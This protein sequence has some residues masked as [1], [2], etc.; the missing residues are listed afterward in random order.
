MLPALCAIPFAAGLLAFAVRRDGPRRVLLV[1]A[2]A[3]HAALA[4]AVWLEPPTEA[5]AGAWF[6]LDAA[7]CLFL[8]LTS[9]LFLAASVYAVGYLAR[10]GSGRREDFEEGF[11]FANA[12]EAVFAGCLLLFLGT[13]TLV[14]ASQHLGMLWVAVEATTLASAP[15][16]YFHRHR[17]S[18]EATWKY[19]LVCSVGIAVALLGTFLLA[20]AC[21]GQGDGSPLVLG[22]LVGA[23]PALA[24]PWL[25]AAFAL[26]LVGYGTK[27][28]LA[29]FHAWLPDAHSEAPSVV[30]ALLS[31]ALLNCAFLGILRAGQVLGA[32]GHAAF[33]RELLVVFGILSMALAA[34]FIVRQ[35]DYKRMLA[36]SS[37][38]HMGILALGVGL[39]GSAV[40]GALLHAVNHSLTKGALFLV[41]GNVLAAY[42]TKSTSEVRGILRTLPLS[43]VLW[44]LG[45]LAVAGSPPFGPFL[46]ELVIFK[47]AV[48]GGHLLIAAAY[49]ALLALVFAGMSATVLGMSLGETPEAPGAPARPLRGE[50]LLAVLPPAA[51]AAAV[52][53]LGLHVPGGLAKLLAAAAAVLGGS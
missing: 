49:V 3:A 33:Y 12:P 27:M 47:A 44:V 52:L 15:L 7:G 50:R 39:G 42:R 36:Y 53:C 32:A 22:S 16:I 43:G 1:G 9:A 28:G 8:G 5:T 6:A 21:P 18:L 35:G 13:M 11:P 48:D 29:P 40:F 20:V 17:R 2:A 38:E 31:G 19:L 23:G 30:S 41:A 34:V 26:L 46:S 51:L 4:A 37:V 24:A 25:K 14:C 10:E 45:F